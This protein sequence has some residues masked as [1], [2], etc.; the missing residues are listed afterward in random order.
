MVFGVAAA[1]HTRSCIPRWTL[2]QPKAALCHLSPG[3]L[4]C[5]RIEILM[6]ITPLLDN[7][8]QEHSSSVLSAA[9]Q[10]L[11]TGCSLTPAQ[12]SA[13]TR[14]KQLQS[15][16]LQK[17]IPSLCRSSHHT[18]S[19]TL[20]MTLQLGSRMFVFGDVSR[21]CS[22][23][24]IAA[25]SS[26]H[27]IAVQCNAYLI[28]PCQDSQDTSNNMGLAGNGTRKNLHFVVYSHENPSA[29]TTG[30]SMTSRVMGQ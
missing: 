30:S 8:L 17:E 25:R 5:S 11:E 4:V 2:K 15:A 1:K 16:T 21:R 19:S 3:R 29:A 28:T 9:R 23:A 6:C 24:S 10:R 13:D 22:H 26:A 18:L 14:Q 7:R 27:V 12:I 20:G